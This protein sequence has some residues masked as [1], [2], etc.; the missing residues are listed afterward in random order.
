MIDFM[1][2]KKSTSIVL[3]VAYW[4]TIMPFLLMHIYFV[5]L[6]LLEMNGKIYDWFEFFKLM[7]YVLTHSVGFVLVFIFSHIKGVLIFSRFAML[8]YTSII[9][10]F[11]SFLVFRDWY[12]IWFSVQV[13]IFFFML[14]CTTSRNCANRMAESS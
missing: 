14:R 11:V 13:L 7:I 12:I 8:S 1:K 4:I 2:T 3:K 5:Y 6:F 10:F 9:V